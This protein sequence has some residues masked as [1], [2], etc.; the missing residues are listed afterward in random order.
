MLCAPWGSLP[1]DAGSWGRSEEELSL[2]GRARFDQEIQEG[3]CAKQRKTCAPDHPSCDG[4][5]EETV[6]R[7]QGALQGQKDKSLES[8]RGGARCEKPWI[9]GEVSGRFLRDRSRWGSER[10]EAGEC[11]RVLATC[12]PCRREDVA[13][14]RSQSSSRRRLG[15][16]SL[17]PRPPHPVHKSRGCGKLGLAWWLLRARC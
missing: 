7:E 8:P 12:D 4:N 5:L 15:A 16:A 9:P 17:W 11:G 2:E 1:T 10:G 6:R 13:S 14:S 3:R